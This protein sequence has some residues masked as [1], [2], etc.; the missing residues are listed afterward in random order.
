MKLEGGNVIDLW[1]ESEA[2]QPQILW[3]D[4]RYLNACIHLEATTKCI[5]KGSFLEKYKWPKLTQEEIESLNK[6][7]TTEEA[8]SVIEIS[9]PQKH[10][11]Q[12]ILKVT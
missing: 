1:P 7:M 3:L 4:V 12:T 5:W 10:Q 9:F 8:Q 2:R 11:M 6:L